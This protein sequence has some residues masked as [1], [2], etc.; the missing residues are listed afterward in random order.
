MRTCRRRAASAG[1]AAS[2][3]SAFPSM[4]RVTPPASPGGGALHPQSP[5]R[6]HPS[7]PVNGAAIPK[8][9]IGAERFG[10]E[11]GAF[12]GANERRAG[13]FERAN[14]GT[15]FLDEIGDMSLDTQAKVLRVLETQRF[16]RIGGKRT[17]DVDVR[18][19]AATNQDLKKASEEGEFR[20]DLYYRLNV[21]PIHL[22]PLRERREDIPALVER[23][24]AL[25]CRENNIP[26][27][28]ISPEAIAVL[29]SHSWPGNIRELRNMV[30]R[31]VILSTGDE[32]SV[33]DIPADLEVPAGSSFGM[34]ASD[35]REARALFERD[36]ILRCLDRH[37]WNITEAAQ[38][39]GIE[40]TN[41][42]RKMRQ[43]DIK[44]ESH[45][46]S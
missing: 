5:R 31:L 6:N 44:R 16:E 30:E 33:E 32:I 29:Q 18:V 28:R 38:E 25:S 2:V 11:K 9:L 22:P 26:P 34:E 15:L 42:H 45:A 7:V 10:S 8:E 3:P 23:F 1:L 12:T 41:L 13:R 37:Q 39:L 40:R 46:K 20:E 43:L 14:G 35:L 24:M 21:L 19:V 27:K 17:I 4:P 36:F